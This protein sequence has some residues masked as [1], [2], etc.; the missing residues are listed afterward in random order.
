MAAGV[1]Y[2]QLAPYIDGKGY[3]LHN[4]ASLPH[5]SVAGACA[6]ATHGS[7]NKNGNLSTA[8]SAM[9]IVTADGEVKVL[10]RQKDGEQFRGAV[11]GLG[12]LGVVTKTTLD[13]Q[14]TFQVSQVVYENLSMNV[15]EHH[16]E[17]IFGSRLQREPVHGL[18]ESQDR[19][20]VGQA[21]RGPGSIV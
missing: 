1:R 9:E 16:L 17:E 7:G 12:G 14:P 6:T 13:V 20:G 19:S 11:V 4:L 5:I 10:S 3:A 8:V 15:L 18:A 2:G 21:T